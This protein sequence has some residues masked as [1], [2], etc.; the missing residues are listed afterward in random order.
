MYDFLIVGAGFS[1]SV[2]AERLANDGKKALVIDKRNHIGG[3]CYDYSSEDGI[4]VQ[5]YGPHIFHTAEKKVFDYM[6]RFTKFN[7]YRHKVIA[8]YRGRYYP[9][10]INRTTINSFYGLKLKNEQEVKDFL[11]TKRAKIEKID[12]SRDVVVS[13]FGAEMYEAFVKHYTKK[14]WDLY[15]EELDRSVLERLPIRYNTNPYYFD[16]KYQGMPK[17]GF[18]QIFEKMLKKKNITVLINT[19]FFEKKNKFK[20][21]KMVYTGKI[22]QFFKYKFGKLDYRCIN[23]AFE[24][25]N[26]KNYQPNSVVNYTDN[27]VEF[28]RTTEFKK[29]YMKKGKKTVICKEYPTWEG[30]PSYPVMDEKNEKLIKKY[31]GEANKLKNVYFA[32]R[33]GTHRY[34]N[35]DRAVSEALKLYEK[36]VSEEI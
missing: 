4:L 21:R 32:G 1:G 15:P 29:F 24:T 13:R 25:L 9:I 12:N 28:T 5:K 23:F 10:P 31:M 20:F 11:E 27:D 34:L 18:T 22:D 2:L 33:L 14:Q 3:N 35:M 30:E 19:D 17:N 6:C 8:F 26:K 7:N 16:D 36:I